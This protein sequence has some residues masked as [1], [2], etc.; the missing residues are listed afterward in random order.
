M[1]ETNS[2]TLETFYSFETTD[3]VKI[4]A[5]K[6]INF[7]QTYIE[8]RMDMCNYAHTHKHTRICY[9]SNKYLNQHFT[10]TSLTVKS[11]TNDF[12]EKKPKNKKQKAK[13]K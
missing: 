6:T 2:K 8:T 1:K 4:L 12:R 13:R 3:I 5:H 9:N 7:K 11:K 10:H